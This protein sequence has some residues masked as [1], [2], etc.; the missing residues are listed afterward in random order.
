M[1]REQRPK[2]GLIAM[3][4]KPHLG[5]AAA[6][7]RGPGEDRR[8][9]GITAHRIKRKNQFLDHVLT[10]PPARCAAKR[11]DFGKRTNRPASVLSG[12]N[13]TVIIVSACRT[14][15]VGPLQ[16]ATIGA[17]AARLDRER[18][19]RPAHIALGRRG[20]SF[21]NRHG[22][23]TP[24]DQQIQPSGRKLQDGRREK[25]GAELNPNPRRDARAFSAGKSKYF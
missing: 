6:G 23:N 19:V 24:S 18:M 25:Q 5:M 17:F 9:A 21:W 16:L 12:N 7:D 13:L 11:S 3:Q 22:E 8:G 14:D 4:Q 10:V 1:L 15:M 20:L 2:H